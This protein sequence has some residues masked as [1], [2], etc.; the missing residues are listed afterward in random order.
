MVH[1]APL[2]PWRRRAQRIVGFLLAALGVVVLVIAIIALRQPNGRQAALHTGSPVAGTPTA[3]QSVAASTTTR[4]SSATASSSAPAS[5]SSN[6]APP[7][8][9]PVKAI[10]LVVLNSTSQAGLAESAA[11]DFR[12]GGW[13]VSSTGNLVNNI[14]STCAYYDPSVAGAQSEATA[15]MAQFPG[16]KRVEP[17]FTPMPAGAIVVV[18]TSDW[19]S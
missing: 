1:I 18:L 5:S 14:V 7:V 17:K 9:N 16:I 11:K 8:V 13:T 2:P 4:P 10:P 12:T 3:S 6:S 15:L 19:T